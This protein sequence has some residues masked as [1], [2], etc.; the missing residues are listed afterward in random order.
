MHRIRMRKYHWNV[1]MLKV[2]MT[3]TLMKWTTFQKF[4]Q[5]MLLKSF[6]DDD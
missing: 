4:L 1:L 2:V 3:L 5:L 6:V